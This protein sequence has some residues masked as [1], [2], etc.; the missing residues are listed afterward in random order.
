MNN[1]SLSQKRSWKLHFNSKGLNMGILNKHPIMLMKML[2]FV[3]LG[4]AIFFW[5]I[6]DVTKLASTYLRI[7][8]FKGNFL[9]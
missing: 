2:I 8:V 5:V 9:K 1:V 6:L 3:N 7:V 4:R